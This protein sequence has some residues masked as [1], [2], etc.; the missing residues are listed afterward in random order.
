MLQAY[1]VVK[2]QICK[3]IDYKKCA[4]FNN[5]IIVYDILKKITFAIIDDMLES[6][7]MPKH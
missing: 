3:N 5:K 1:I 2:M 6:F 7:I 4:I